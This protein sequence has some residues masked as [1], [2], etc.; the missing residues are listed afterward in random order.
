MLQRAAPIVF[1][2]ASVSFACGDETPSAADATTSPPDGGV[3]VHQ[4]ASEPEDGGG[5]TCTSTAIPQTRPNVTVMAPY[6]YEIPAPTGT[7]HVGTHVLHLHDPLRDNVHTDE[8]SDKREIVVQLFYPTDVSGGET[9]PLWEDE[10]DPYLTSIG[11]PSHLNQRA[12]THAVF[13]VEPSAGPSMFPVVI[14]SHG[15]TGFRFENWPLLVELASRGFLVASISHTYSSG[16]VL[17]E[18]GTLAAL[19]L[20][21]RPND[22]AGAA[23]WVADL[24][25][26]MTRDWLPDFSLVLDAL[27]AMNSDTCS[28]LG[29]RLDLND[30]MFI[31]YSFGGASS[32]ERCSLEARCKAAINFD[33]NLWSDPD[34][35]S[36]KPSMHIG[37]DRAD[38][39]WYRT[40]GELTSDGYFVK[41]ANAAHPN[42][43]MG[44]PLLEAVMP[45]I[46]LTR[47]GWG[48]IDAERAVEIYQAYTVAFIEKTLSGGQSPLLDGPSAAYPEAYFEHTIAGASSDPTVRVSGG[49][50]LDGPL[51]DPPVTNAV[52]TALE[53]GTSTTSRMNGSFILDGVTGDPLAGVR[54]EQPQ[55]Q[56]TIFS[57]VNRHRAWP[58]PATFVFPPSAISAAA[59]RAGIVQ[60]A[61]RGMVVVIP[62]QSVSQQFVGPQRDVMVTSTSSVS[63]PVMHTT[64]F[65]NVEPGAWSGTVSHATATCFAEPGG[66]PD[67]PNHVDAI[68]EAG[69]LS[70][71]VMRCED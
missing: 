62:Q 68:V 30:L 64:L 6:L 4:D 9:A 48:T 13:D 20:P 15:L 21:N 45:G 46:D 59:M 40:H 69:A 3:V 41:I 36:A 11:F 61:D 26:R 18:D 50:Y 52:I 7:H 16:E 43:W 37:S 33:G 1:L 55:I 56:T 22:P 28:F 10:L 57:F 12:E 58:G 42:F 39:T 54:I 29:G 2:F 5:E 71:A 49:L 47:F 60:R 32:I 25:E 67:V 24:R 27:D 31:G 51:S 70:I 66:P 14:Y 23:M 35:G 44:G 63:T 53:G 65:F 19:D 17:L 38:E 34:F 8:P